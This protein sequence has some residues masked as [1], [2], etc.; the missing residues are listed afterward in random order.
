ME[1]Y[2]NDT[3]QGGSDRGEA[4]TAPATDSTL[5]R[6]LDPGQAP[7]VAPGP[8]LTLDPEESGAPEV[9]HPSPNMDP[10]LASTGTEQQAA[11]KAPS[12][13]ASEAPSIGGVTSDAHPPVAK[14]LVRVRGIKEIGRDGQTS[15]ITSWNPLFQVEKGLET[16][17]QEIF[18]RIESLHDP[19]STIPLPT[20][21]ARFGSAMELFGR[22]QEAIA[23]QAWV[24]AST[25]ALLSYWVLSTWFSDALAFA[26]GLVIVGPAH[27]ADLV[28]RALRN[29]CR[30]PLML[31][32]ADVSSLEKVSWD[33]T[34]T[35]LF[36]DPNITKQMA[37]IL[38]CSTS[39][40]Y[41]VDTAHGYKDFFCSK[42][43]YV[44][45]EAPADRTPRC[46]LQVRVNPVTARAPQIIVPLQESKVQG[47]QNQLMMYRQKNLVR[48]YHSGF[49]ARDLDAENRSIANALGACVVDCPELQAELITLLK[50]LE[51]QHQADRATSLEA[52]TVEATLALAHTGK[53]QVLVGEVTKEVNRLMEVRGERLRCSAEKIG[54]Q[55][56]RVNLVTRRLGKAGNGLVLDLATLARVHQLGTR[57]GGVGLEPD[58]KNL[59]CPL[60]LENK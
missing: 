53:T 44:G 9:Q 17:F 5:D 37:S 32:R 28:L 56:K 41:L 3:A 13:A 50:P 58:E 51:D 60:C 4:E 31:T 57:Y 49:D 12:E 7:N 2:S 29:Y 34:P 46:S 27:E 8:D 19:L 47:L 23:E 21:T 1:E 11:Q 55:L 59:H 22:L 24:P 40:G 33:S 52:I 54:H 10:N 25:S 16:S 14:P 48:V 6:G 42:C 30:Y 45:E 35:L 43:A 20:G 39:R 15:K 18:E 36:Y 38:T 26:P